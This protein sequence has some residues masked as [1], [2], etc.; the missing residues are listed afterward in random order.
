MFK[1]YLTPLALTSCI[2][3]AGCASGGDGTLF[4]PHKPV[5]TSSLSSLQNLTKTG[6]STGSSVSRIRAQAIKE[7][8]L[9]LG[10]QGGLAYRSK[11]LNQMTDADQSSLNQVFNFQRLLLDHS[12]LPPVLVEANKSL[13][14][15]GPTAIRLSGQIYKIEQQAKFVTTPPNWRQYLL[16][17][18]QKPEVPDA[19]LLPKNSKERALWKKEIN[20]GWAEGVEQANNIYADNL[21]KLKRDFNGMILY[22]KLLAQNIVSKPYVGES[23]L[24]TTSNKDHSE[25]RLNDRV[26]RITALPT[27]NT[28]TKTWKPVVETND[29]TKPVSK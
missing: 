6:T 2:L 28:D 9:T 24:G 17:N 18:F 16:L 5:N 1:R 29:G 3:L 8:A 11:Q 27:L 25:L 12:V 10:A 19:T 4:G 15:D 21:A 22:R 23:D 20:K 14:L 26:L 7:T 13:S